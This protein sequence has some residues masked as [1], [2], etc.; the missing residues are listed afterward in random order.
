MDNANPEGSLFRNAESLQGLLG[1]EEI[2]GEPFQF[3]RYDESKQLVLDMDKLGRVFH[4]V[5]NK[6]V[7]FNFTKT[8]KSR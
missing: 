7:T 4:Q 6:K 2:L 8:T 1:N 3:V 5:D